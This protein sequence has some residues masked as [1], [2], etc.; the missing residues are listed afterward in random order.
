M[1]NKGLEIAVGRRGAVAVLRVA[2]AVDHVH[3]YQLAEAIQTELDRKRTSLVVDL[4]RLSYITSA[5][6]N[7]LGHAVA[8]F[9]KVGGRLA[10]VRPRKV[11]H[12][13][14]FETV[15]VDRLFPWARTLEEALGQ[16]QAKP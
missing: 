15:G 1:P 4:A 5:G 14:F 16:V 2:G 10:F 3:S 11:E 7:T 13:H 9:E 6:I 12:W 8:Q